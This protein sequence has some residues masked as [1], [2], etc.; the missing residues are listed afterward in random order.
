MFFDRNMCLLGLDA[1]DQDDLFT[2]MAGALQEEGIV[3]P[4]YLSALKEREAVYPTGQLIDGT[5]FAIPHCDSANVNVSQILFGQLAHPIE[6]ADMGD[7][8]HRIDVSLVF[9]LAMS[10]PHEQVDTLSNLFGLFQNTEVVERLKV[11]KSRE[12][13][14]QIL[15][16]ANLR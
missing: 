14:A 2:Q 7:P 4:S 1:T 11:C 9:M 13:F 6:F 12:N 8:T 10:Q 15:A 5:G 16:D 3:K